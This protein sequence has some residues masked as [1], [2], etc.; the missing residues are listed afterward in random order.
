MI[1]RLLCRLGWHRWDPKGGTIESDTGTI[2][3]IWWQ[4]DD[5]GASRLKCILR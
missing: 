3:L 2:T 1:R 5:C 4:C